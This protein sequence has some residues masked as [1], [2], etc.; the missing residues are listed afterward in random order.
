MDAAL[1][2]SYLADD[3]RRGP[4]PAG[5]FSGAAGGA[6]CG[7]LVR[8]SIVVQG[9]R[10]VAATFDGEGCAAAQ[11]A[12]AAVSELVEGER[13]LDAARVGPARISEELGGLSRQGQHAADLAADA[14]HR[15]LAA[16]V[17]STQSLASPPAGERVLVAMSGGVDSA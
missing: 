17:S 6:P 9:G 11:A 14:L 2:D 15:A 4:A 10:I 5:A 12:G 1:L 7:D 8:V 13:A 16:L 3:S